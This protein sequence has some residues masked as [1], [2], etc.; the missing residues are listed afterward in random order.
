V[1]L[2]DYD[3]V[4]T[5]AV[6]R[7]CLPR[8]VPS[9]L[10]LAGRRAAGCGADPAAARDAAALTVSELTRHK[11][12]GSILLIE[13]GQDTV[14]YCILTTSWSHAL[15][16]TVLCVEELHVEP[17]HDRLVLAG[18]LLGMLAKVAPAGA[19]AI[20][21]GPGVADRKLRAACARAGFH[22]EADP[23]MIRDMRR[24]TP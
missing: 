5:R 11:A 6:Y 16:G 1:P 10:A 21:V 24:D 20:R 13:V 23:G 19:V 8:D 12:G 9:L 3:L 15:G 4:S 17:R 14:G 7:N 22:S 18:D 2:F